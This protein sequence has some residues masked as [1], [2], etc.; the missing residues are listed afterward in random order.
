MD[1][2]PEMTPEHAPE[3]Q[4]RS[5]AARARQR[6]ARSERVCAQRTGSASASVEQAR[7]REI[8]SYVCVMCRV[9]FF[10]CEPKVVE[11]KSNNILEYGRSSCLRDFL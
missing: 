8:S 2:L 9:E 10:F 7:N 3:Q 4:S 11:K 6:G 5:A 1:F